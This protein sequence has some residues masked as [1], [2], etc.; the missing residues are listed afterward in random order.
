MHEL[1]I[2]QNIFKVVEQTAI[3]NHL[4][5][6]TKVYLKI[7][8]FRQVVPEFLQFAFANVVKGTVAAGAELVIDIVPIS[9]LCRACG[10]DFVIDADHDILL[11]CPNCGAVDLEIITG[12][13]VVLDSVEGNN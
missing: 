8:R 2:I 12:K 13:E 9:G 3:D 7:G 6:I 5:K 1:G 10:K 4:K 11:Q